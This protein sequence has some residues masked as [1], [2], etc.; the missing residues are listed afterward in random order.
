[1]PK[2]KKSCCREQA[3]YNKRWGHK[4]YCATHGHAYADKRDAA[5]A[6]RAKMPDCQ[7]GISPSCAGKISQSMWDQ[8][9]R[10]CHWCEEEARKLQARYEYEER[11]Q[12]RYAE[13]RTVEELK[14]WIMDYMS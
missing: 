10:V 4:R 3:V 12:K 9:L 6:A 5:L 13:A 8:G 11:K 14:A 2:C 7:S 1:M